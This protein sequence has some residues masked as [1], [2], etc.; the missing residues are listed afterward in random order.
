MESG[1]KPGEISRQRQ[2]GF[3]IIDS[4]GTSLHYE[5]PHGFARANITQ[6]NFENV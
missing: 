2:S 4:S 1:E 3:L 5:H 6:F